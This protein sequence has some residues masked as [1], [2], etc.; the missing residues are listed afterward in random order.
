MAS[1][2]CLRLRD[3]VLVLSLALFVLQVLVIVPQML[4]FDA[5]ALDL[6]L[7]GNVLLIGAMSF[8][9]DMMGLAV[10]TLELLDILGC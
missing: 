5:E 7:Q 9:L 6:T 3:Q 10:M 2:D 8:A 4:V 1:V